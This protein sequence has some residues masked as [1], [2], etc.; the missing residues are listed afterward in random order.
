MSYKVRLPIFEGPFDLL[1]YLIEA[2]QV[3]IYDIP[4]A[5]ITG[6]YLEYIEEMRESSVEVSSDFL[7]L[8]AELIRIKSRMMLPQNQN[9][10]QAQPDEDP[11]KDLVQRLVEYRK[12]RAAAAALQE[13]EIRQADVFEKPQEDISEFLENPDEY[14]KLDL[15]TFAD[16][17]RAFLFRK[18]QIEET[19]KRYEILERRREN[20]E[21][22]MMGIRD[23]YVRLKK[24]GKKD[25]SLKALMPESGGRSGAVV[26]FMAALNLANSGYLSLHQDSMYGEI[27]I[28]DGSRNLED[29][30]GETDVQQESDQSGL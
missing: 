10:T 20:V 29:Y 4:I 2:S 22:R 14:L 23:S 1:V 21:T 6:Q 26:T 8:A 16:A 11:R 17:F 24:E 3:S 15:D 30:S 5:E 12:C 27:L 9:T 13:R 7:V 25:V 18:Q 19:R 28:G